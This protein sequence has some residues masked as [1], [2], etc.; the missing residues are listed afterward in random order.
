[1]TQN[2]RDFIKSSAAV[3][4]L[5]VSSASAAPATRT[6][7]IFHTTQIS[8]QE[9]ACF[10]AGLASFNL[11]TSTVK[12]GEAYGAYGGSHGLRVLKRYIKGHVDVIVAAGGV[13]SQL[14]A[15]DALTGSLIPFVYMSG[16]PAI[17]PS[18][19]NNGKYCGVIL[20]ALAQYNNAM[21]YFSNIGISSSNVWLIQNYNADMTPGELAGWAYKSFRFFEA[22]ASTPID[23]PDPDPG[24]SSN[25]QAVFDKEWKR[26]LR[27][28]PL[29]VPIGL[30]INPDPYFRQTA[31][32]FRAALRTAL[33]NA[34][35]V[36][37]PFN[38]YGPFSPPDFLLPNGPTLS[39]ATTT[40]TN[41]AYYQ[42][43]ARTG[44]V[45]N[46]S[47][48]GSPIPRNSIDSKKWDGSNWVVA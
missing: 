20:N 3:T 36:F 43:G 4:L 14:A 13:T 24:N 46:A 32:D 19:P 16:L 30:I 22:P 8:D 45:L 6:I 9:M 17:P 1:M 33:G 37:Y 34:P 29:S 38:D 42:L 18:S 25:I 26:F 35:V 23:N 5:T 11:Q 40:D 44:E 21:N 10:Q 12:K 41:N 7:G 39:S 27:L 47:S 15:S 31:T 28:Y 2:R 48:G